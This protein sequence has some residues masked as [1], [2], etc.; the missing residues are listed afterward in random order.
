MNY[1][2][3]D[4][5]RK[6]K[7]NQENTNELKYSVIDNIKNNNNINYL[8]DDIANTSKNLNLD[9]NSD[10]SLYSKIND[11]TIDFNCKVNR[12]LDENQFLHEKEIYIDNTNSNT[13]LCNSSEPIFLNNNK[14]SKN[15]ECIT[16]NF[17]NDKIKD[18]KNS[19]AMPLIFDEE[20]LENQSF[21][22]LER[23]KEGRKRKIT[24]ED[25]RNKRVKW[26]DKIDF[27]KSKILGTENKAKRLSV[28]KIENFFDDIESKINKDV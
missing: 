11:E 17:N 5:E 27:M 8:N 16:E 14:I 22:L 13:S 7:F 24:L 25:V 10:K 4:N 2:N 15:V 21:Q 12:N 26:Q 9:V 6:K 19:I 28:I 3:N 23:I 18:K 1:S 20:S